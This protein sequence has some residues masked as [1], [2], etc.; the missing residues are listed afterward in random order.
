MDF[1]F[2]GPTNLAYVET[3]QPV[4]ALPHV[5]GVNPAEGDNCALCLRTAMG[6]GSQ[7]S[8]EAHDSCQALQ[9]ETKNVLFKDCTLQSRTFSGVPVSTV[10]GE[11]STLCALDPPLKYGEGYTR[12]YKEVQRPGATRRG[13]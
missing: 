5:T 6:C 11:C 10:G 2:A 9:G 3:P 1:Q 7:S 13:L 4:P 8:L 12:P